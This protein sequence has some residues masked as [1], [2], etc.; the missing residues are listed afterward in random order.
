MNCQAVTSPSAPRSSL[1]RASRSS[2]GG[3]E[4]RRRDGER[5]VG[6]GERDVVEHAGSHVRGQSPGEEQHKP[7]Y[8]VALAPESAARYYAHPGIAYRPVT[9][10][11]P[12]RVGVAWPPAADANPVIQD[13]VR[14]CQRAARR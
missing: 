6:S 11:S 9:G 7:G 12:S 3:G 4:G 5:E 14:C 1:T 13:F 8:G 2:A 10:V